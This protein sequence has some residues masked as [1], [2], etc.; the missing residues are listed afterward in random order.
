M[1]KNLDKDGLEDFLKKSFEGYTES[2][3]DDTWAGIEA[4]LPT[5]PV[6]LKP[7]FVRKWG[8]FAAAA[9][10]AGLLVCQ[11]FFFRGRLENLA[12]T[13]EKS[14]ERIEQ[15]E[16]ELKNASAFPKGTPSEQEK[17]IAEIQALQAE[18]KSKAIEN[19]LN[20]PSSTERS[21]EKNKAETATGQAGV[22]AN[23]GGNFK[24]PPKLADKLQ[25]NA[26]FSDQKAPPNGEQDAESAIV[27]P[28]KSGDSASISI[29]SQLNPGLEPKM[30]ES[31]HVEKPAVSTSPDALA[32]LRFDKIYSEQRPVLMIQALP[33]NPA[34]KH[35]NLAAGA[36]LMALQTTESVSSVRPG[37][38]S[39]QQ[40]Q[41]TEMKGSTISGELFLKKHLGNGF[42]A[43]GG[44]G[45][46]QHE[47][48]GSHTQNLYFGNRRGGGHGGGGQ[49][50]HHHQ[51]E[52][53]YQLVTPAGVVEVRVET[54]QTDPNEQFE[55]DEEIGLTIQTTKSVEYLTLPL[56]LEKQFGKGRLRFTLGGGL[57]T[58]FL[59][60][61]NFELTGV[62]IRNDRFKPRMDKMS[63]GD[64]S[65][66]NT[67]TF[68]WRASAGLEFSLTPRLN[69][70]L[71]PVF[72]GVLGSRHNSA[73]IQ[74]N[75]FSAGLGMAAA[76][77]F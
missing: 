48:T 50:Q 2:P 18:K 16:A 43:S 29:S 5:A 15:L 69:L 64:E 38:H 13:Q 32:S 7:L 6:A 57:V 59:S 70:S 61:H 19:Q 73:F 14:L 60:R 25:P 33:I 1:E 3:P 9:T 71:T 8:I 40:V 55:D 56:L 66:L 22:P 75:E 67:L 47:S 31:V 37:H 65:N 52:F 54:E 20:I 26:E 49:G 62:E 12:A 28:F 21:F 76:Y 10:V 51:H 11:Y 41:T 63:M 44:L 17:N 77:V 74:S 53:D 36:N 35:G 39:P 30:E 42:Y 72:S 45:Y 58:S 4:G 68:D 34:K 27:E 24:L 46:R 23:L